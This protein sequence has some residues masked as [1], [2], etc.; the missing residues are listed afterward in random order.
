MKFKI[1]GKV[2]YVLAVLLCVYLV[3]SFL[4]YNS[5]IKYRTTAL[6]LTENGTLLTAQ[7]FP[8]I[9][10]TKAIYILD[11]LS[12]GNRF[13]SITKENDSWRITDKDN[14]TYKLKVKEVEND[15]YRM[16]KYTVSNLDSIK[17]KKISI[18]SSISQKRDAN[19]L[20]KSIS[21]Y[22]PQY[23]E[24]FLIDGNKKHGIIYK[25]N[26][27]INAYIFMGEKKYHFIFDNDSLSYEYII[28][29]LATLSLD[30]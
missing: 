12:L 10:V 28:N 4:I 18:F 27:E 7:V 17:N 6:H 20:V 3:Y 16:Y 15:N 26:G 21:K 23:Q 30:D 11:T 9:R 2:F 19:R 8:N 25:Y 14:I 29:T 22:V 24:I 1:W 5:Y 13:E